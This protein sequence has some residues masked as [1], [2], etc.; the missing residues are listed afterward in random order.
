MLIQ[1]LFA[2]A[3]LLA[4]GIRAEDR[5]GWF[6]F[7]MPWNDSARTAIDQSNTLKT[8]AGAE[9][10]VQV[11]PDGHFRFSQS[12]RRARFTG[13]VSVAQANF[14][15]S[16]EALAVAARMAKFGINAVRLHLMDVDGSYG[17]FG[18][19][20][21]T[22]KLDPDKLRRLD[23][24][25]A[26]L[27]AKGIYVNLGLHVARKF[28]VADGVV[29]TGSDQAKFATLWDHELMRLQKEYARQILDHTNPYTGLAWKADPAVAL[30]EL[31]NENSMFMGW[32][33]WASPQ[34]ESK[35]VDPQGMTPSYLRQLDS[36]WN[37]WLKKKYGSDSALAM[38]WAGEGG[39]G[40]ELVTENFDSPS[41]SYSA[42]VDTNQILSGSL[43]ERTDSACPSGGCLH[44]KSTASL[45]SGLSWK[46]QA[47]FAGMTC[48]AGTPLHVSMRVKAD[49]A[50]DLPIGFLQDTS[51]KWYGTVICKAT[52]EWSTCEGDVVV[53]EA[54]E[55]SLL[56]QIEIGGLAGDVWI[57]SLV[58]GKPVSRGLGS[59][60][61]L[62]AASVARLRK[63]N[64]GSA[65]LERVRDQTRFYLE[66]EESYQREMRSFLLDT[67]GVK[68]PITFTNNWA[69]TASIA[70]QAKS[71]YTD[72]HAYWDM[73][74]FPDGDLNSADWSLRN[75]S[76]LKD[77]AGST[78]Q[79]LAMSKVVGKPFVVSEYNHHWPNMYRAEA[80]SILF[81]Y[82]G[83]WDADAVF[84]HS[85]C[86]FTLHYQRTYQWP[87]MDIQSDPTLLT[88]FFQARLFR[89]G[90]I[91]PS[92]IQNVVDWS[93]SDMLASPH[94][95]S[96]APVL[97]TR[98]GMGSGFVATMPIAHGRFDAESTT[99]TK[100]WRVAGSVLVS[101]TN[102][103]SWNTASGKLQID[104]PWWQGVVGFNGGSA[105]LSRV[106]FSHLSTAGHSGFA[107]VHVASLD[108]IP[109]ARTR[110]FLVAASGRM[111]N[112]GSRWNASFT[113]MLRDH[114]NE[115]DSVFC[116]PVRGTVRILSRKTD[117]IA[118][119]ALDPT[120]G[121]ARAI[122]V[123]WADDT[124]VVDLP[125]G[126]LWTE[127][128]T[129]T[130]AVVGIQPR[131]PM[132][133]IPSISNNA[134]GLVVRP[135][136]AQAG[137][138]RLEWRD[139]AGRRLAVERRAASETDA[140]QTFRAPAAS[141]ILLWDLILKESSSDRHFSGTWAAAK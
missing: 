10:F 127:I 40:Q 22:R 137:S 120:G 54:Q 101:S 106:S 34:M 94:V 128:R 46:V 104:N 117:G 91:K 119:W 62:Q 19:T 125:E 53:S 116:E 139:L 126:T 36:M 98:D 61:S 112:K 55:K 79:T 27:K 99:S 75:V 33:S 113:G 70:S 24:F 50:R 122:P 39:A 141:G 111:E 80:P 82:M 97:P 129:D 131:A 135:F 88:Q 2:V 11:G 78:L 69:S 30:M 17:I 114:A 108:S 49:P 93:E 37:S 45:G 20:T 74:D 102:E 13:V 31:V 59:G 86:D 56:A 96:D 52:Q 95:A 25:Q 28:K 12:L 6:T 15:D 44:G 43:W 3:A 18:S 103:L 92:D 84:W 77:P 51:F 90:K 41:D 64:T 83:L 85:W 4:A 138:M 58:I 123:R 63:R 124:I 7:Y 110:H 76:E 38:A 48:A 118:A 8:P 16:A 72:A 109:L 140:E 71:D 57:D 133:R 42:F 130:N 87:W 35:T 66:I 47:K 14:P 21:S 65:S 9:G 121:R 115:D 81:G 1:K 105:E 100:S 73:L 60:E 5:S 132:R 136:F 67:L 68:V 29:A 89:E 23:W 107:A 32:L 26:C 134:R